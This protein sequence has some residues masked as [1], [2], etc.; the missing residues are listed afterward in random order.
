M[1]EEAEEIISKGDGYGIKSADILAIKDEIRR[2][3]VWR[4]IIKIGQE[5]YQNGGN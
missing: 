1:R 3:E 4:E 2:K 5:S